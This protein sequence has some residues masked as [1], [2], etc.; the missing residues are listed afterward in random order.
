M[1]WRNGIAG[2]APSAVAATM[3]LT[4]FCLKFD[5]NDAQLT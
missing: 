3:P 1:V 4:E 2:M 5:V